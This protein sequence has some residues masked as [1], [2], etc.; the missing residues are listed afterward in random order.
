VGEWYYKFSMTIL[1]TP[2]AMMD[3]CLEVDASGLMCP[4][5]LLRLKQALNKMATGDRVKV[6]TT[7][8]AAY[9]DFG[10]YCEQAGHRI[11]EVAKVENSVVFCIC[12]A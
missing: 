12:K 9:L 8:P 1:K 6:I 5:P 2:T 10:V 11:I 4:L 7:D 3:S